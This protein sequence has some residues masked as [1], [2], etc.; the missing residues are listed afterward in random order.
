M[1]KS[2]Q[3]S[4]NNPNNPKAI[5]DKNSNAINFVERL[6]TQK[7]ILFTTSILEFMDLGN[8]F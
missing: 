8:Q 4:L 2:I 5:F 6:K 3:K 1:K 7:K